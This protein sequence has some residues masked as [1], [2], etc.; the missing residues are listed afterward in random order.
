VLE[1]KGAGLKNRCEIADKKGNAGEAAN[2]LNTRKALGLAWSFNTHLSAFLT[3]QEVK[4]LTQ[5]Q[6]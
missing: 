1:S 6:R 3:I 2:L 4:G 5:V